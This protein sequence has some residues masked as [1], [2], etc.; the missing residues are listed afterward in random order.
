MILQKLRTQLLLLKMMDDE[1]MQSN[2][3]RLGDRANQCKIKLS[4]LKP[5]HG[6]LRR[7]PR[8]EVSGREK[9]LEQLE[10]RKARLVFIGLNPGAQG[11]AM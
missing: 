3:S 1:S 8:E 4:V 11:I 7:R 10:G 5:Y 6:P 2:L 9:A